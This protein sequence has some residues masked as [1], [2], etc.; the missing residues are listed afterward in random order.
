MKKAVKHSKHH[1]KIKKTLGVLSAF[2]IAAS[3]FM[4][5]NRL[6][7]NVISAVNESSIVSFGGAALFVLGMVGVFV[8][9]RED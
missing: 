4:G 3:M 7:G 1:H 6:T 2:A 8:A 9:A 5:Y